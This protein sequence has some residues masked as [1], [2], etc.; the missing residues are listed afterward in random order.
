MS[1]RHTK[2]PKKERRIVLPYL[3]NMSN[4][5]KAKLTKA[6]SKILKFRQIKVLF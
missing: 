6:V 4:I 1:V 3:R 2:L 5:A